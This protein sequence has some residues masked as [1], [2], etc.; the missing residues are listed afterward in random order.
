MDALCSNLAT[1]PL[2]GINFI[3][4]YLVFSRSSIGYLV[5]NR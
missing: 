2:K 3:A 1:M 4:I 5:S